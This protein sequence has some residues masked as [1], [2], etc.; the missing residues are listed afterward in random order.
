MNNK[1]MIKAQ[2]TQQRLL[3]NQA[4]E[5]AADNLMLLV[6]IKQSIYG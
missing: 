4:A 6:R 5:N 1:Q 2:Q 3:S